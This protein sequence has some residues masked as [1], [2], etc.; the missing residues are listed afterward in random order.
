MLEV[1]FNSSIL[2][3]NQAKARMKAGVG[4]KLDVLEATAQLARDEQFL[5]EK[6]KI[7]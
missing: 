1:F 4:S 3:L 5:E 2:S 6:K 7:F